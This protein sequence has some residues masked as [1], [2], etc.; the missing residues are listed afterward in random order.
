M[1]HVR[2]K[3]NKMENP[4]DET[5]I[6]R[7]TRLACAVTEH[8]ADKER[9]TPTERWIVHGVDSAGAE[10]VYVQHTSEAEYREWRADDP[11]WRA[12]QA[13]MF[14]RLFAGPSTRDLVL[15][16]N[17]RAAIEQGN[18]ETAKAFFDGLSDRVKV[19]L[20]ASHSDE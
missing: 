5:A 11:L 2:A 13:S 4:E 12:A 18:L 8:C 20:L 16:I 17:V 14:R 15:Q 6:V 3:G 10:R 19:R 9:R 7:L 1:G